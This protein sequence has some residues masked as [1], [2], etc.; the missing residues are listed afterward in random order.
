LP[1]LN[2]GGVQA[3]NDKNE[4]VAIAPHNDNERIAIAKLLKGKPW[5]SLFS[6]SHCHCEASL[7]EA[8][9]IS[10][11]SETHKE[12]LAFF[13]KQMLGVDLNVFLS[14]PFRKAITSSI[15]E[16]ATPAVGGRGNDN[17]FDFPCERQENLRLLSLRA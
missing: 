6:P 10:I 3:R 9:A 12:E 4:G 5:Q 1:R 14:L 2:A 11:Y 8:V 13:L 16:I 17:Q 15:F 7:R